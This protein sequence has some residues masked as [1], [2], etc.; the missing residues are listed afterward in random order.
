[1]ALGGPKKY[2]EFEDRRKSHLR[3]SALI[4]G[5]SKIARILSWT[6]FLPLAVFALIR[7]R[8]APVSPSKFGDIIRAVRKE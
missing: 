8:S 5:E 7:I 3:L 1:M 4:D 2:Y 6:V